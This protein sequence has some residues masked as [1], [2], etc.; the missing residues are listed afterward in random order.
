MSAVELYRESDGRWRWAFRE[1]AT[2]KALPSNEDYVDVDD[3]RAA[4]AAAY[5][6]V[7]IS[8]PR[9][10]GDPAADRGPGR[11]PGGFARKA[12]GWLTLVVVLIAWSRSRR[13]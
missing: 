7:P 9:S 8:N 5:P 12:A 6:G 2:T 1:S 10:T 3:A 4:A 13:R 11:G